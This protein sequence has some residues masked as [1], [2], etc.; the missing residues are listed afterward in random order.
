[1]I[2][3]IWKEIYQKRK[4]RFPMT[5]RVNNSNKITVSAQYIKDLSFENPNSPNSL[6]NKNGTPNIN[7]EINVYA[8]PL[9]SK[10][11]EVS[12]AINGKALN[13]KSKIFEIEL[14][15]AGVF[16]L[17]D[18]EINKEDERKTVLIECPQLLF[19]FARSIVSN[20]TRDGGFMPLVIQPIDFELLYVERV[21][22][23]KH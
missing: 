10:I 23:E 12:L 11:Y 20:V 18:V 6:S 22:K 5:E 17:P 4:N 7:V 1:M 21:N 15:Y 3:M 13:D 8:K 14:V 19:P 16:S 2:Y 9:N